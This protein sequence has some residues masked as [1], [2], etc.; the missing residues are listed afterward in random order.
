V[1]RFA[2][3]RKKRRARASWRGANNAHI[4]AR[5]AYAQGIAARG[6]AAIQRQCVAAP[7]KY[8]ASS[9]RA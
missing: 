7:R 6:G 3:W 1:A 9:L 5:A 4:A 2:L 8:P